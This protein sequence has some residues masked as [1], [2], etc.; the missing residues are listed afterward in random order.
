ME[1][2]HPDRQEAPIGGALS[3]ARGIG[4]ARDTW[5]MDSGTS[6]HVSN[7]REWD[8]KKITSSLMIETFGPKN[9]RLMFCSFQI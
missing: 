7:R 5:D 4:E 1:R 6:D 9:T 3:S 2:Q 8:Q